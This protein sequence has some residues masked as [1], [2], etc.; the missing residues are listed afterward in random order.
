MDQ[1]KEVVMSE[2]LGGTTIKGKPLTLVGP[3]IHVGEPVPDIEVLDNNFLPVKLSAFK[4]KVCVIS[5][6]YSLETPVCDK[7]T[8]QFNEGIGKLGPNA[9]VLTVSMDLPFAQKRWCGAAA[10]VCTLSD[11]KDANFGRAFGVLIKESRMLARAVFV[12]DKKGI[13]RYVQYVK[14]LTD[15]PDYDKALSAV[16]KLLKE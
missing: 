11:Y 7:Q 3:E 2:R 4:G 5:T 6:V 9:I 13:V 12:V 1:T 14:E 16:E 8:H 10:Q 15:H